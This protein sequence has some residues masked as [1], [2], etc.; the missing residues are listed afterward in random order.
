MSDTNYGIP[1][2]GAMPEP[3]P[4]HQQKITRQ[5]WF[6]I[7]T[8]IGL[9]VLGAGILAWRQAENRRPE[10]STTLPDAAKAVEAAGYAAKAGGT[11]FGQQFLSFEK[12]LDD[13]RCTVDLA[14][15]S[16]AAPM[17]LCIVTLLPLPGKAVPAA[18]ALQKAVNDVGILGQKLVRSSAE[19]FD[20]AAKA[21]KPVTDTPR[22]HDKGVQ[23]TSDGWKL[24]YVTYRSYDEH[25]EAQPMLCYVLQR[26]STASDPALEGMNQ[27]LY[28]AVK[29]GSA[30]RAALEAASK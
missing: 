30:P 14:G 20:R 2:P 19:A 13:F 22:L 26:Q 25:A 5:K 7:A 23:Q 29:A 8:V 12:P 17:D 21:M 11:A 28:A 1:Y 9:I 15:A 27:A 3:T 24:T 6:E 10:P 18:E 16:A 4:E